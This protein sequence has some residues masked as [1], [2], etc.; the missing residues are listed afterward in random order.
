MARS[1]A[2]GRI[3]I[4]EGNPETR[5]L[6]FFAVSDA[7]LAAGLAAEILQ[8]SNGDE[9]YRLVIQRQ[10]EL[11]ITARLIAGRSG[12]RFLRDLISLRKLPGAV[13]AISGSSDDR[14][15][16]AKVMEQAGREL[17]GFFLIPFD[18]TAVSDLVVKLL[19]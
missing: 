11:I 14:Q 1:Q 12:D 18:T 7:M 4:C 6:L 19:R 2:A 16:F 15:V 13:I 17:D 5:A 8:T 10:P 3:L 9:G